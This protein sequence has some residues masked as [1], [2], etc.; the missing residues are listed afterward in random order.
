MFSELVVD[1]SMFLCSLVL[2]AFFSA[3]EV[4]LFSLQPS[5]LEEISSQ[6]SGKWKYVVALLRKPRYLLVTILIGNTIVTTAA[7]VIVAL[8]TVDTA[9]AFGW[10]K[11][12]ALGIEVVVVTFVVIVLSEVTPKVIAARVPATFSRRIAFPLY[13]VSIL[14]YPLTAVLVALVEALESRLGLHQRQTALKSDEIKTLADVVSEHGAIDQE[15]RSIIHSIMDAKEMIV[16][17]VMTPRTD[18][19]ALDSAAQSFDGIVDI[20]VTKKHSRIP[21]FSDTIDNIKGILYAKD[22]LPLLYEKQARKTLDILKI[23]REPL[24]VPE[25]KKVEDLLKEFQEKKTRIAVVVDEYGG[26][27]GLVTFQNVVKT[28]VGDISDELAVS[29][30]KALKLSEHSYRFSAN[31]GIAE[32]SEK[33][34]VALFTEDS[35]YDTL[36]GFLFHLF[37]R[38]PKER[39]S[40]QFE[41]IVFT[42]QRVARNRIL[43]VLADIHRP[44]ERK[45]AK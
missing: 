7:A 24:F 17:E 31:I 43:Y 21:V 30:A 5:T 11:E 40:M 29:E 34:G 9:V 22:V 10:N 18:M 25:S 13:L 8:L 33:L 27:A 44:V 1:G 32:A 42:V 41:N 23:S 19:V 16:R 39:E 4:A 6:S 15:E 38:V 2:S 14:F 45:E 28:I 12:L 37:G 35:G 3:A 26:T 36:G 20:F